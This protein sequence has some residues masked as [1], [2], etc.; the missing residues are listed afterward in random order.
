M[1][2]ILGSVNPETRQKIADL[3]YDLVS[4][5]YN[6]GYS[7]ED[8]EVIG[9]WVGCDV[10]DLLNMHGD[11]SHCPVCGE[12]DQLEGAGVDIQ[13]AWAVQECTCGV[14][15]TVWEDRYQFYRSR[16]IYKGG[17]NAST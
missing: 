14:C 8:E 16:V 15:G 1:A 12:S 5:H 7:A 4:P 11:Q 2:V 9:V 13:G 10:D 17:E 6:L 3:G